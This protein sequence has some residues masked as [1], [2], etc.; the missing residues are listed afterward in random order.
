M[1]LRFLS[2]SGTSTYKKNQVQPVHIVYSAALLSLLLTL[3]VVFDRERRIDYEQHVEHLKGSEGRNTYFAKKQ[4]KPPVIQ[5]TSESSFQLPI[6][7]PLPP[8]P[9]PH[10]FLHNACIHL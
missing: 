2:D 5:K 3:V 1:V 9:P 6:Y 7:L 10:G 8:P 4:V